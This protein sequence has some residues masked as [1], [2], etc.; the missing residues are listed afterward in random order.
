MTI[1]YLSQNAIIALKLMADRAALDTARIGGLIRE[2]LASVYVA[3]MTQGVNYYNAQHDILIKIKHYYA[4]GIKQEDKVSSNYQ[5]PHP[6]FQVLLDQKQ[7]YVAGK[8]I[9]VS[10]S[11]AN[12]RDNIDPEA[13][14]FQEALDEQLG[15][16]FDDTVNE[17]IIGAGCKGIEWIHL[18]IDPEGK[19]NY[20]ICP[21]EQI[22]PVYDTQHQNELMYVI[23]FYL[24]ELIDDKGQI[25]KR[26]KVEWWSKTDVTYWAEDRAGNFFLDPFYLTNPM[27][28]WYDVFEITGTGGT[29]DAHAWGRVPFIPLLNNQRQQND[30][31]SIK[32]LIDAY[33]A[34][35][36]GW[37]ND[38]ED[39][40]EQILVVKG[41][42]GLKGEAA[43]GMTQLA[44]LVKNL[45]QDRA[46]G[47]ESEGAVDS[48]KTPIPVEAKEKF[49]NLTRKAIFYFGKGV[50]VADTDNMRSMTSGVALQF[51]Y[52][53]LDMKANT[54][55]IKLK[56]AL[57]LFF[58]FVTEF[59][60]NRDNT[61][62][63][64]ND[65]TTTINKSMIFNTKEIIDGLVAVKGSI[66]EQTFLEQ[67]PMIDDVAEEMDRLQKQRD[68]QATVDAQKFDQQL[69][70][71]QA[72]PIVD[73]TK[74]MPPQLLNQ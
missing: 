5:L 65:I 8:P 10:V 66:S 35:A 70:L 56:R 34:V 58:W 15:D 18:Y 13:D 14:A 22:L 45:K 57:V 33:D 27:P 31:V 28:H 74:I 2:Y 9:I 50:D 29:E 54:T 30:L 62:Y 73:P 32:P 37:C 64:V 25:D 49:L 63:D 3:A 23:R 39:F 41:F 72:S 71:A 44:L 4:D 52:A 36:S 26:F 61:A 53:S 51:L 69:K 1:G 24:V 11:G 17:W 19:L 46:V 67:L 59:I 68:T 12:S 20:I 40:A 47:V 38:L 60:N 16:Q 48:L 6:F 21:A 43:T 42:T 7:A 55:I